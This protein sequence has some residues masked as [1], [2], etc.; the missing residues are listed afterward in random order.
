MEGS[1][2]RYRPGERWRRS[3]TRA[4]AVL[5]VP[6]R[7]R[8]LL[9]RAGRRAPRDAGVAAPSGDRRPRTGP[10]RRRAGPRR[11]RVAPPRSV[12]HGRMTIGEAL[13]DQT[14]AAG[15][16]N[17]YRSEVLLGRPGVAVHSGGRG[18]GRDPAIAAPDGRRLPRAN[19]RHAVPDDDARCAG[20][21]AGVARPATRPPRLAVYGRAGRPA[22]AVARSS[23]PTSSASCRG[24]CTGARPARPSAAGRRRRSGSGP[25]P[26]ASRALTRTLH[27][28]E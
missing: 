14:A 16:G 13:L 3:P 7:R 11:G 8:C 9:R 5:E 1:W 17:V 24:G 28:P 15:I 2:H 10:A 4:V 12:A 25:T 18:G 6:T 26:L 20:R 19:V 23:E 21:T 22:R 27:E